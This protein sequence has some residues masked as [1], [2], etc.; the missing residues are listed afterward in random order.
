MISAL[1]IP[2]VPVNPICTSTKDDRISVI[3][4]IPE[5]GFVPTMAVAFAATIVE[6]DWVVKV[7]YAPDRAHW[8]VGVRRLIKPVFRDIT[9]WLTTLN[10]R[11]EPLGGQRDG[12]GHGC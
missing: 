11:A 2:D 12:W 3:N 10:A 8:Q 5:T 9:I 7:S 1:T 6:R 4:V